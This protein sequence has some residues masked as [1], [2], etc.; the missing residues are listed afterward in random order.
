MAKTIGRD[1][2]LMLARNSERFAKAALPLVVELDKLLK[3]AADV[4]GLPPVSAATEIFVAEPLDL[5]LAAGLAEALVR[6]IETELLPHGLALPILWRALGI[7]KGLRRAVTR[8]LRTLDLR[9]FDLSH[10]DLTGFSLAG[11]TWS[12][13]TRWPPVIV[14]EIVARSAE[15][16]PGVFQIDLE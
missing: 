11:A 16:Q 13:T 12:K 9:G 15:T 3:A 4:E 5:E 6:T 8:D 7:T 10:L 1:L 2:A 14:D